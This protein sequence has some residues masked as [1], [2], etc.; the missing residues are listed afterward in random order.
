MNRSLSLCRYVGSIGIAD[1]SARF[2]PL[3]SR[4]ESPSRSSFSEEAR[5][6]EGK[7]QKRDRARMK[8]G[9][10][11]SERESHGKKKNRRATLEKL[12]RA[13]ALAMLEHTVFGPIEQIEQSSV[14]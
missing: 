9:E 14:E 5:E 7:V 2:R 10:G 13:S 1:P 11:G 4:S 6:C 8:R 12:D 3:D